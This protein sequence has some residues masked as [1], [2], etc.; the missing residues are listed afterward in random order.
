MSRALVIAAALALAGTACSDARLE[1]LES[2]RKEVCAC[3]TA[4]CAQTAMLR[5]PQE[6]SRHDHAARKIAKKIVDCY[7]GILDAE[8][9]T[10]DPD[11]EA[12][13]PAAP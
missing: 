4:A 1:E 2:I 12:P 9:P 5:V 8:R 6:A 3:K 11:A 13:E 7:R 10:T